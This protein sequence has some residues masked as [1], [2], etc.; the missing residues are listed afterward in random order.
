VLKRFAHVAAVISPA[1]L[2]VACSATPT[3]SADPYAQ[4]VDLGDLAL[5][6]A[7]K[8]DAEAQMRTRVRELGGDTLLFGERGRS[9]PGAA[10]EEIAQRRQ[11]LL[12]ADTDAVPQP[13]AEAAAEQTGETDTP[14]DAGVA[15]DPQRRGRTTSQPVAELV[16]ELWYYGAALRCSPASGAAFAQAEEAPTPLVRIAPILADAATRI[17]GA[18]SLEFTIAAS[19][20]T[21]DI[22][23]VGS[24][25]PEL[26]EPAIAALLR[27]R[28]APQIENGASLERRVRTTIRFE[29]QR[30]P[31]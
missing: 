30:D 7:S 23:I 11:K 31:A 3:L 9:A 16:G 14:A 28:Y 18:V 29:P 13:A 21:K 8:S 26:E 15:G 10:P 1:V 2:L 12:G 24:S 27:W 25:A 20:T 5:L 22:A 17:Y 19:G 6:S 4:C